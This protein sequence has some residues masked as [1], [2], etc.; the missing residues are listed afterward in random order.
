MSA[1]HDQLPLMDLPSER[2]LRRYAEHRRHHPGVYHELER[3]AFEAVKRGRTRIGIGALFEI[4]RWERGGIEKDDEGWKMNADLRA[5][6]ARALMQNRPELR[7]LFE[8][9][10]LRAV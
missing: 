9:R 1:L 5:Y 7:G 10:R 2:M 8:T 6:Y 3:L 4:L